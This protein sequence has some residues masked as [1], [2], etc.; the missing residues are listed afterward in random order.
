MRD[1]YRFTE[2]LE[3]DGYQLTCKGDL[4]PAQKGG[5]DDPSWPDYIEDME[6]FVDGVE[7]TGLVCPTII[8]ALERQILGGR[9]ED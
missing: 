5:R 2:N 6:V 3:Y 8:E 4:I 7:I 1:P 9:D